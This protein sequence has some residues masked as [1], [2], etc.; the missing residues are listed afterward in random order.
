[1]RFVSPKSVERQAMQCLHRVRSRL[2][3]CR[4][5]LVDQIRGLLAEYGIIL[6]QQAI[7]AQYPDRR[8]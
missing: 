7:A 5:P 2:V 6:P 8:P 4:T 1:M 3:A